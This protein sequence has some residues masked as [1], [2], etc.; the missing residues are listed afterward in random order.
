MPSDTAALPRPGSLSA[1]LDGSGASDRESLPI[2]EIAP[3]P[4]LALDTA[5]QS[6]RAIRARHHLLTIHTD[7]GV[8]QGATFDLDTPEGEAA[9][10][11]WI[12][13]GNQDGWNV[14]YHVNPLRDGFAKAKAA[15]IDVAA[16]EYLVADIDPARDLW[17][18][19]FPARRAGS[20]KGWGKRLALHLGGKSCI[21]YRQIAR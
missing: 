13:A 15:N 9:C 19:P 2:P 5:I 16:V 8:G 3:E 1:G 4:R 10:R 17:A 20:R 6:L 14:Y 21:L 12:E 11:E 7:N 18:W